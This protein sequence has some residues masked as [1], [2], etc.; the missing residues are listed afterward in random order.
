MAVAGR[1]GGRGP[2]WSYQD[3][4]PSSYSISSSSGTI[5]T[6][7]TS[8]VGSHHHSS[9][10]TEVPMHFRLELDS[11]DKAEKKE[12]QMKHIKSLVQEFF[13]SGNVGV[14]ERW[15]T[16]LGVGWVLHLA[17]GVPARRT[18]DVCSWTRAL[19]EIVETIGSTELL[20]PDRGSMDLPVSI[21]EGQEAPDD[22]FL[23]RRVANKL[24]RRLTSNL[25]RRNNSSGC[26]EG[27]STG[28]G[29]EH[30]SDS[31]SLP[32]ICEGEGQGHVATESEEQ[33]S[34]PDRQFQ[35]A[36]F[37][38][39]TMLKMLP[40][41]DPIAGGVVGDEMQAPHEKL[42]ILLS[43]RGALSKALPQIC[44]AS[45]SRTSAEVLRIQ[46][47]M[48][49]LL[50]EK[51]VTTGGAIWST[52]EGIRARILETMEDGDGSSGTQVP[53]EGSSDIHMATQAAISYFRFLR[54]NYSSLAP[55][56][57][58]KHVPQIVAVPPMDSMII[59]MASCLEEKLAKK[60]ESFQNRSLGFLF[61]LNNSY[62]ISQQVEPIWSAVQ[63]NNV[64]ALNS[65]SFLSFM[66][67]HTADAT[68]KIGSYMESYLQVSW[69]PVLSC[70]FNP[71]PLVFGK[72]YSPLAKFES[73][74]Q[75]TYTTQ[76]LWKVPDPWLRK[77]LRKAIAKE[78]VPSYKEYIQD[79]NITNPRVAPQELE[80]MLQELFEG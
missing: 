70:L 46:H 47:D 25:F 19:A 37:F 53:Q 17:D 10:S 67:A 80:E 26:E 30:G 31:V 75:K 62:L 72:S 9:T 60:S 58:V 5:S 57:S 61:L 24:L 44:L 76:K 11:V 45:S 27:P 63:S 1:D 32:T 42:I 50:A 28:R 23:L 38:Q 12:E 66:E 7:Y 33:A 77:I 15:L 79:N 49:R 68:R 71:I 4:R 3:S 22:Q 6:V 40:F 65:S 43:I 36:Q 8:T 29:S 64:A 52:M 34:I 55:V 41:V 74:F 59:E 16:E 14:V 18:S 78:I 56:V 13:V 21:C 39:E 2:S 20:F 69:A 35:C 48:V 73:E 51:E 54:V